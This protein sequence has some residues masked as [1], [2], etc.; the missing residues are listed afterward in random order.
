MWPRPVVAL[1]LPALACAL[2]AGCTVGSRQVIT[3]E[4]EV[5]GFSQVVL[6]SIRELTVEY[7]GVGKCELSGQVARQEVTLT[8]ARD[9]DAAEL[10]GDE[11][12]VSVTGRGRATVW[13]RE[14]LDVRLSGAGAIR[15]YGNPEV[16]Q[17]ITGLGE[18]KSLGRR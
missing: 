15:Y 16:T 5:S 6:A 13:A 1:I 7:S 8:G 18:V 12:D 11:V 14:R 2:L 17:K 4:R 3:R 10:A 9:Y